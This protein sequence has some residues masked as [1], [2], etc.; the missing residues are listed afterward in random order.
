MNRLWRRR[1]ALAASVAMSVLSAEAASEADCSRYKIEGLATGM[2]YKAVEKTMKQD[3][4]VTVIYS[5]GRGEASAVRYPE[6]YLEF[7]QRVDRRGSARVV[8]VRAPT[9]PTPAAVDA[10]VAR[11]GPPDDGSDALASGLH[12]GIAVWVN[13]SCGVVLTAYKPPASWWAA[14]GGTVLQAETLELAKRGGSPATP[15][16]SAILAAKQAPKAAAQPPAPQP[17]PVAQVP[18][19]E[20]APPQQTPAAV[21]AASPPPIQEPAPQPEQ[22][23]Q[24]PAPSPEP[25]A[26]PAQAPSNAEVVAAGHTAPAEEAKPVEL[27]AEIPE[28][29]PPT[30]VAAVPVDPPIDVPEALPPQRTI[31]RSVSAWGP[32]AA[33]A[34]GAKSQPPPAQTPR[35]IKDWHSDTPPA[36]QPAAP[37]TIRT[38][39]Y[40]E[41]PPQRISAVAPVFPTLA[42]RLNLTGHVTL[43]IVVL[44]DGTVADEPR[45]V[46]AVPAGRGFERAAADAVRQW[47]FQ[48][49]T[50]D[51]QPVAANLTVGVDF[52]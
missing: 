47:R 39:R 7:D 40:A 2:T 16:L 31:A 44:P 5:A 17:E 11:L 1:V 49:A 45:V 20:P 22:V 48:P 41:S 13:P 8:L 38:W 4:V 35:T 34:A 30:V 21:I 6:A 43:A 12:D 29:P 23:A 46:S 28:T 52:K 24:V 25:E 27:P 9:A 14:E 15:K 10:L 3:G 50:R 51:G 37:H 19:Q 26:P 33:A 18:V 42:K 32:P 36:P